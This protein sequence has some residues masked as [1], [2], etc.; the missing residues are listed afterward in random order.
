MKAFILFIALAL[1]LFLTSSAFGQARVKPVTA[2]PNKKET[3]I[4]TQVFINSDQGF[5]RLVKGDMFVQA[6]LVPYRG[7][8]A[9]AYKSKRY[10]VV[11]RGQYVYIA[12]TKYYYS[13][14]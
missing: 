11:F 9:F 7:N 3:I 12:G 13:F 14:F 10:E 2:S 4:R 8:W 1:A 6:K 5:I